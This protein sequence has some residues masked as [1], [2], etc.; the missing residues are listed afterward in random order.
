MFTSAPYV[1]QAERT[2]VQV[3]LHGRGLVSRRNANVADQNALWSAP[4]AVSGVTDCNPNIPNWRADATQHRR[5]FEPLP[6]RQR[7]F[8]FGVFRHGF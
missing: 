5:F 3:E 4:D 8:R 7:R 1:G 2:A 6:I